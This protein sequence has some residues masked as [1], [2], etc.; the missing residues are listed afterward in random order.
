MGMP[1]RWVDTAVHM[2]PG[3]TA[4]KTAPIGN[5]LLMGREK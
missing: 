1:S 5:W 3:A 4:K 2:Q